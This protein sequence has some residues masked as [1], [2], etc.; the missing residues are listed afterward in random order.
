MRKEELAIEHIII[1]LTEENQNVRVVFNKE[2]ILLVNQSI[3][4]VS[5]LIK[6]NFSTV[7]TYY[8]LDVNDFD[9]ERL[10]IT[11]VSLKITLYYLYMYNQ[12]RVTYKKQEDRKLDFDKKDFNNPSTHDILFK[13]FKEKYPD[14]WIVKCSMLMK[15][16]TDDVENYYKLRE[17]FYNK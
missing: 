16:T 15:M 1:I 12:W 13:Y 7:F 11:E 9:V 5:D 4:A 10:D 8:C 2:N 3:E 14:S 6:R 17:S